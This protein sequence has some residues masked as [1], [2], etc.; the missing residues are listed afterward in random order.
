M[1]ISMYNTWFGDCFSLEND[2]QKLFVDFGIHPNSPT[3]CP[4]IFGTTRTRDDAHF[5][6]GLEIQK[7]PKADFLLTHYHED[8]YSGLLYMYHNPKIFASP[9]F[10]TFY[11]PD[12]WSMPNST[13]T[14]SLLL[15]E[16]LL[17]N[18]QLSHRSGRPNLLE[19]VLFLCGNVNKVVLTKRGT[20][21]AFNNSIALWPDPAEINHSAQQYYNALREQA[22]LSEVISALTPSADALRSIVLTLVNSDEPPHIDQISREITIISENLTRLEHQLGNYFLDTAPDNSLLSLNT[23]GNEISIVF[24]NNFNTTENYLFTGDITCKHLT[25]ITANYD[26]K[27]PLHDRY[28]YIKIPHHGTD[29]YYFDFTS[30][31]PENIMIPNGECLTPGYQISCQYCSTSGIPKVY[32]SNCNWCAG[33]PGRRYCTGACANRQIVFPYTFIQII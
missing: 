29:K 33:N 1:H 5:E 18:C 8:H 25:N 10:D 3:R 9:V 23:F 31:Q 12:I 24:H 4:I 22:I 2:A 32:C 13:T 26:A 14:I 16:E 21:I 27:F 15:L 30:F 11:I 17:K 7:P 19:L 28:K 6:I 20:P